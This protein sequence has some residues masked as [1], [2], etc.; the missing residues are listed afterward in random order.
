[1]PQPIPK[2]ATWPAW[3]GGLDVA[4]VGLTLA[5]GFLVAS[6]AARNTDVWLHLAAGRMLTTGEY[7]LGSDPMSFTAADRPWVNHSWLFDLGMYLLY[8]GDGALLVVLKAVAVAAAVALLLA[9]RR[10]G[11]ALWP[12]AVV[13]TLAVLAAAPSL[14]LQ[15]IVGSFLFLALTLF[16]VFRVPSPPGSWRLPVALG[17]TFCLW[18]NVD[19]WFFLGPVAVGLL[20]IGEAARK[21]A[22]GGGPADPADPLGPLPDAGTLA[23]ALV[24][25]VLACMV[26]PHHVRVWEL[27][28]ELTATPEIESDPRLGYLGVA[29]YKGAFWQTSAWGYNANGVAYALLLAAGVYVTFLTGAVGR[30]IGPS[31]DVDP[32]PL[33][34]ALLWLG[35]AALSLLTVTAIPFLAAVTVPLVASRLNA[36]SGKVALGSTRDRRTRLLLTACGAGR[37]VTLAGVVALC[38]VAWPGWDNVPASS[39]WSP[40]AVD[41]GLTRRVEW[42]VEPDPGLQQ[43]AEWLARVRADGAVPPD[44]HGMVA[45]IQ[46]ANYCAWFAPQE[47]VFLNA[48]LNHHRAE[49]ADFVK[50]RRGLGLFQVHDEQPDPAEAAEVFARHHLGYVAVATSAGESEYLRQR[51]QLA[52]YQMWLDWR[53]WSPWYLDGR[54]T[55]SGWRAGPGQGGPL[56]DR[57]RLDPTRLAFG[58]GVERLPPG[59]DPV[60]P[61]PRTSLDEFLRPSQPASPEVDEAVRWIEYRQLVAKRLAVKADVLKLGFAAAF[62]RQAL[63]PIPA[64]YIG[65]SPDLE[66]R[67]RK[68]GDVFAPWPPPGAARASAVLALRAAR[69]AIAANPDHPDGYFALAHALA[70]TDLPMTEAERTIGRI[71][72][73]RQCLSR[74]PPPDQYRPG[75]SQASPYRVAVELGRLYLGQPLP[76]TSDF[77]GARVDVGVIGDYAGLSLVVVAPGNAST[78]GQPFLARIPKDPALIRQL[79]PGSVRPGQYLLPLDLARQALALAVEYARVE[80]P[81]G[82]EQREQELKGLEEGRKQLDAIV[83]QKRRL[84]QDATDKP[85]TRVR[86]RFLAALGTN[87]VG[88]AIDILKD[89]REGFEKE[90]GQ[91]ARAVVFQLIALELAVGRLEDAAAH[92]QVVRE[93]FDKEAPPGADRALNDAIRRQ[94]RDLEYHKAQLEGNYAE[95]GAD[96]ERTAGLDVGKFL[97][98]ADMTRADLAGFDPAGGGLLPVQLFANQ[99]PE[100]GM[101]ATTDNPLGLLTRYQAGYIQMHRVGVYTNVVQRMQS[102]A[103]FFFRRGFLSLLEGDIAGAKQRFRQATTAPPPGWKIPPFAHPLAAEYLRLIEYAETPPGLPK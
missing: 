39:W 11:H 75:L 64:D 74:M 27:P 59:G 19:A 72:A 12:W 5:I 24:V 14:H 63:M 93:E 2:P 98:E 58:P 46:L 76:P 67:L 96:F 32:L 40:A 85:Q 88:E 68:E 17:V 18:S 47:K 84:Y 90:F 38:A 3:F 28:I 86:D 13:G 65:F 8:R 20:L 43:A 91:N 44:V 50:A 36:M 33:P 83:Q 10:P 89:L 87:L 95:A 42:K 99:W 79:P 54:T 48:R 35:F 101:L 31:G 71:T 60:V 102:D 69:R 22:L 77:S 97:P 45:S 94:L 30:L 53:H 25:G 52:T 73:F 81:P 51:V 15:P 56:F 70:Q 61:A 16:L 80:L 55:V 1:V 66:A 41:P 4:L 92:L 78:R 9:V 7:K 100:I 23:R 103:E 29:P 21:Y 82:F 34:H 57:L 37:L 62:P 49:L 6:F 26:N